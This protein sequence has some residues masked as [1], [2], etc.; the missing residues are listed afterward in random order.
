[1]RFFDP[2]NADDLALLHSTVREDP[3]LSTVVESIEWD[4]LN[5]YT[6][7]S[8]VMLKGYPDAED[9]KQAM[10][11]TIADVASWVLRD[12]DNEQGVVSMQQGNRSITYARASSWNE[13]PREWAHRLARF[14]KRTVIYSI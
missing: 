10:R 2:N 12:Y 4:I 8:K 3:N 9:L 7:D 5:R 11:R 1:M 14:D 13:W 6:E